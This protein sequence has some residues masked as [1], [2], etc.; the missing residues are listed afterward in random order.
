MYQAFVCF[1]HTGTGVPVCSADSKF[2]GLVS[3]M[4]NRPS[5]QMRLT[6]IQIDCRL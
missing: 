1:Y 6:C 5:E 4:K 2:H 3:Y